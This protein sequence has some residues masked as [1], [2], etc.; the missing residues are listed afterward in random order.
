LLTRHHLH[1]ITPQGRLGLYPSRQVREC[2]APRPLAP[3]IHA[4]RSLWHFGC[5]R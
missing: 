4:I 5:P 3:N 1:V 2:F